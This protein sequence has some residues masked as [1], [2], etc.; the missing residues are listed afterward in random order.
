MPAVSR[1]GGLIGCALVMLAA[2]D[3]ELGCQIF[4]STMVC[5]N[6]KA[7]LHRG[8]IRTHR[9]YCRYLMPNLQAAAWLRVAFAASAE[10]ESAPLAHAHVLLSLCCVP[11]CAAFLAVWT[12]AMIRAM[13]AAHLHQRTQCR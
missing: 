2:A 10:L 4:D 1:L 6:E 11:L 3:V 8:E 13:W 9:G 7:R 5:D 12:R